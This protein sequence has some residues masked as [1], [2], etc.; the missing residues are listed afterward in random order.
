MRD[1]CRY[2]HVEGHPAAS[3]GD[4]GE[5]N[6]IKSQVKEAA[7]RGTVWELVDLL[8]DLRSEWV[9]Q[10]LV[11]KTTLIDLIGSYGANIKDFQ[12]R[13]GSKVDVHRDLDVTPN[14]TSRLV[15]IQGTIEEV[16]NTA[17]EIAAFLG[18][19][20]THGKQVSQ[21]L[22]AYE[23]I[24]PDE[25]YLE[26][27]LQEEEENVG[28][29]IVPNEF[30]IRLLAQKKIMSW[31][32]GKKGCQIRKIEEK[33]NIKLA[34]HADSGLMKLTGS[35]KDMRS[36]LYASIARIFSG[37]F[38]DNIFSVSGALPNDAA[39]LVTIGIRELRTVGRLPLEEQAERLDQLG[40]EE[41]RILLPEKSVGALMGRKGAT[42]K[43]IQKSSGCQINVTSCYVGRRG[44]PVAI[45]GRVQQIICACREI[46]EAVSENGKG[47]LKFE[48]MLPE[49][50]LDG[51]IPW[52]LGLRGIIITT[53]QKEWNCRLDLIRDVR[54]YTVR[55]ASRGVWNETTKKNLLGA[56]KA[57]ICRLVIGIKLE[58]PKADLRL[59][60]ERRSLAVPRSD[61]GQ[62]FEG[63]GNV[64]EPLNLCRTLERQSCYPTTV[65]LVDSG[66]SM[67]SRLA[68][69]PS[70]YGQR[71]GKY[72]QVQ[73]SKYPS[74]N[75]ASEISNGPLEVRLPDRNTNPRN[76]YDEVVQL[77]KDNG[78]SNPQRNMVP[79]Y[80]D[81]EV[82]PAISSPWQ[83]LTGYGKIST[84]WKRERSGSSFSTQINQRTLQ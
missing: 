32:I 22:A 46:I 45:L 21:V 28:S 1:S 65:P 40:K 2:A 58:A 3:D 44:R 39:P 74:L 55:A 56:M 49:D 35:Y 68:S 36:G 53:I 50:L 30:S 25:A 64:R 79:S 54:P 34:V 60:W 17:F 41:L 84:S 77:S 18:V 29:I 14:S 78:Y 24:T 42:V 80:S 43:A 61:D 72:E 15:S 33:Y 38:I 8:N 11:E 82:K 5:V 70:L 10:F 81:Q 20:E 23:K 75:Q 4:C 48:I 26:Q 13:G 9:L 62:I 66:S 47:Y 63:R 27:E 73:A 52:M 69:A 6:K 7:T 12:D 59:A 51:I 16:T 83:P 37:Q 71:L 67:D 31:I 19:S 76:C 57:I